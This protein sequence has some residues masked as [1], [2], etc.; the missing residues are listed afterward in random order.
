MANDDPIQVVQ[1]AYPQQARLHSR[2]LCGAEYQTLPLEAVHHPPKSAAAELHWRIEDSPAVIEGVFE[3][4]HSSAYRAVNSPSPHSQC[5]PVRWDSHGRHTTN[6]VRLIDSTSRAC[7]CA[8]HL[9]SEWYM[10]QH[11]RDTISLLR[12]TNSW[13]LFVRLPPAQ[14]DQWHDQDNQGDSSI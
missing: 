5:V 1:H 8:M 7:A 9:S 12:A 13:K 6:R 11:A 14:G 10:V 3:L 2:C 4:L